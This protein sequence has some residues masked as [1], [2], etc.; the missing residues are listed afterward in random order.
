MNNHRD[1][2]CPPP[3]EKPLI[4]RVLGVEKLLH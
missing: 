4:A 3:P 1:Y 2:A